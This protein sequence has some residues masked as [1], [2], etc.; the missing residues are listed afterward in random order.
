MT[1]TVQVVGEDNAIKSKYSG[2]MRDLSM[3][4]RINGI[5]ADFTRAVT[6]LISE[7]QRMGIDNAISLQHLQTWEINIGPWTFREKPRVDER[8]RGMV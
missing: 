1:C 3:K 7:D 8:L 6:S 5:F 2:S 4:S